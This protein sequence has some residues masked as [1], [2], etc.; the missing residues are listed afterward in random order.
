M[1]AI[2]LI[3]A[4]KP[5]CPI[6]KALSNNYG[7]KQQFSSMCDKEQAAKAAQDTCMKNHL[8]PDISRS[9]GV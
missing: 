8:I 6:W 2:P 5:K 4:I 1:H 7:T 9:K 3:I